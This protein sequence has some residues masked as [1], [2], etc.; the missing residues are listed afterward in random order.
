M[1]LILTQAVKQLPDGR[2]LRHLGAG[3]LLR[4]VCFAFS[5]IDPCYLTS[6]VVTLSAG[7]VSVIDEPLTGIVAIE[8]GWTGFCPWAEAAVI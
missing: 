7:S 8:T 5:A 4:Q 2:I 6:M 1:L 3:R